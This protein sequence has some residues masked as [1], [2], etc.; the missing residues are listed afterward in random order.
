MTRWIL[1]MV[2]MVVVAWTEPLLSQSRRAGDFHPD[3][4]RSSWCIVE[5]EPIDSGIGKPGRMGFVEVLVGKWA[6]Y[7]N[8][9]IQWRI[10]P[11]HESPVADSQLVPELLRVRKQDCG[12]EPWLQSLLPDCILTI[13]PGQVSSMHNRHGQPKRKR[14]LKIR[15]ADYWTPNPDALRRDNPS[16]WEVSYGLKI[17]HTN[18]DYST[19]KD[20]IVV[21][22]YR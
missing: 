22:V 14:A 6:P 9:P 8:E 13:L 21:G 7:F 5:V 20:H 16:R 19:V 10:S 1:V 3:C 4:E 12:N 11:W 18:G 15:F 2:V 17:E